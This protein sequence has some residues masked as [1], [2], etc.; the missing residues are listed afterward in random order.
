MLRNY[1]RLGENKLKEEAEK[2][3]KSCKQKEKRQK[4]ATPMSAIHHSRCKESRN[5]RRDSVLYYTIVDTCIRV[6]VS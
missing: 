6:S 5:A 2:K 1:E 4:V 3:N